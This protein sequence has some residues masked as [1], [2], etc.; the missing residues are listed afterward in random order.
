MYLL[1]SKEAAK[2]L[3]ISVSTLR[4][5]R[6]DTIGPVYKKYPSGAIVYDQMDI[7]IFLKKNSI[8]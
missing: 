1:D 3:G 2:Y 6:R 5:W 8:Y 4:R 7:D